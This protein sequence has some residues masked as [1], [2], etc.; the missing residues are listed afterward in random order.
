M[1]NRSFRNPHLYTHL[2]DWV[3]VDERTTNFPKDLWDPDDVKPDWY[4]NQIGM[5]ILLNVLRM[6]P[7]HAVMFAPFLARA[8]CLSCFY[9]LPSAMALCLR[10]VL[11]LSIHITKPLWWP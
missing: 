8:A 1:S 2:V 11:L 6:T 3:D 4:A 7:V 5:S 10:L 9:L